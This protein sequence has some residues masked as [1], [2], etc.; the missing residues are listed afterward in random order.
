[1]KTK[2]SPQFNKLADSQIYG[3]NEELL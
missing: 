3:L 1:M 2:R